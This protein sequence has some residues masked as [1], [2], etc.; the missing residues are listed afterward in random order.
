MGRGRA[1]GETWVKLGEPRTSHGRSRSTHRR[2]MDEPWVNHGS[3]MGEINGE[4]WGGE[5]WVSHGR[6]LGESGMG[7]PGDSAGASR[8]HPSRAR[9]R[10]SD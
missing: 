7:Q 3:A 2:I 9:R 6:A 10:I 5:P 8:E 1:L 4:P